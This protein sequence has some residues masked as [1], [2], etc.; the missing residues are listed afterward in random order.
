MGD[1]EIYAV[2]AFKDLQLI[3]TGNYCTDYYMADGGINA[4]ILYCKSNYTANCRLKLNDNIWSCSSASHCS[5][6]TLEKEKKNE[7]GKKEKKKEK[8][9]NINS[10]K[11]FKKIPDKADL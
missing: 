9:T 3:C 5:S 7:N 8:H 10:N 11:I 1:A 2:E 6:W 4:P